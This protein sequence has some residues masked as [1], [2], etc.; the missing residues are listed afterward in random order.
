[1]VS[2]FVIADRSGKFVKVDLK[3]KKQFIPLGNMNGVLRFIRPMNDLEGRKT[4]INFNKL[5]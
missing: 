1:M 5:R 4:M 3:Q 2:N